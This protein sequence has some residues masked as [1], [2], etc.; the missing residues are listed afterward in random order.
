MGEGQSNVHMQSNGMESH[1]VWGTQE[2]Q[3]FIE[4]KKTWAASNVDP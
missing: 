4:K 3:L 2:P 1:S